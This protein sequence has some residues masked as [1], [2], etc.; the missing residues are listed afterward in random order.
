MKTESESVEVNK[1]SNSSKTDLS[2]EESNLKGEVENKQDKAIMTQQKKQE[3][4]RV[5]DNSDQDSIDIEHSHKVDHQIQQEKFDKSVL[6][7]KIYSDQLNLQSK[8]EK[9]EQIK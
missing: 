3:V 2:D 1:L 4:Q 8:N 5:K 9:S 6:S 7:N